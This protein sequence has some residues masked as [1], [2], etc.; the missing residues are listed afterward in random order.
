[1]KLTWVYEAYDLQ[2]P[3]QVEAGMNRLENKVK[4]RNR[5]KRSDNKNWGSYAWWS[6][7]NVQSREKVL[8]IPW[9]RC[10][11]QMLA[12][13]L[14]RTRTVR[15]VRN[16]MRREAQGQLE[17]WK[18]GELAQRRRAGTVPRRAS[19]ALRNA[20]GQ[21][22]GQVDELTDVVEGGRLQ[23]PELLVNWRACDDEIEALA[24][25]AK[26]R[27]VLPRKV[28]LLIANMLQSRSPRT[29]RD[30]GLYERVSTPH[31]LFWKVGVPHV[32]FLSV[33]FPA[34]SVPF[35]PSFMTDCQFS[36]VLHPST[37]IVCTW[38]T[39]IS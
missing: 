32:F 18:G 14:A 34:S 33:T 3:R 5:L 36:V 11:A 21:E 7:P 1:M 35:T 31:V 10:E 26:L 24:W 12:R 39:N 25:T 30:L 19:E 9:V 16:G 17:W 27:S 29:R 6:T 22:R 20:R 15:R 23:Q 38:S 37:W 28:T 13:V 8:Y 2:E 4:M